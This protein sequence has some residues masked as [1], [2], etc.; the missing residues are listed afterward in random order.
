MLCLV[1]NASL[2]HQAGMNETVDLANVEGCNNSRWCGVL[3]V[4]DAT[5]NPLAFDWNFVFIYYCDGGSFT[6][7]PC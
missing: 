5:V 4:P 2:N 7:E 3:S 1:Y 6:G